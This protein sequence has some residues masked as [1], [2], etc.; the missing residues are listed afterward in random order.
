MGPGYFVIA[1]LGC[2]DGGGSCTP[3]AT[4]QTRY[5]S[6]G[7][8]L[9]GDRPR[10]ARS[11]Q[12]FRFS[13]LARAL[14]RRLD[15][16]P[17]RRNANGRSRPALAAAERTEPRCRAAGFQCMKS[18]TIRKPKVATRPARQEAPIPSRSTRRPSAEF[19]REGMG[20]APKE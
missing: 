12:Q 18:T 16:A 13:D 19:E 9:G 11:Q 14:P 1:I 4:L 17:P 15:R 2:A 20:V 6:A 10:A 8:M 3:V 7:A 5:A